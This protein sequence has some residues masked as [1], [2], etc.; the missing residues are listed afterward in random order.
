[1]KVSWRFPKGTKI[2]FHNS[3]LAS[4]GTCERGRC[5]L[6]GPSF[7]PSEARVG[8]T[9]DSPHGLWGRPHLLLPAALWGNMLLISGFWGEKILLLFLVW[10]NMRTHTDTGTR[11]PV[12]IIWG[13]YEETS[14][15]AWGCGVPVLGGLG[16]SLP[17]SP[18]PALPVPGAGRPCGAGVGGAGS[19]LLWC[20]SSF[21]CSLFPV[22]DPFL[23]SSFLFSSAVSGYNF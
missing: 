8:P 22:L 15:A 2:Y 16:C 13:Q 1:M 4:G 23:R 5:H 10:R 6:G 17:L 11:R 20:P 21:T 3:W 14:A 12:S 7:L 19:S 18:A 9:N